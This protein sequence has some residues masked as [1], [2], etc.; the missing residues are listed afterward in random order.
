M[1]GMTLGRSFL[2][3]FRSG[4]ALYNIHREESFELRRLH[5]VLFVA[6]IPRPKSLIR[7]QQ[8]VFY[9]SITRLSVKR[10]GRQLVGISFVV[11]EKA[12]TK[13]DS[14]MT[15]FTLTN[16]NGSIVLARTVRYDYHLLLIL[17]YGTKFFKM[18]LTK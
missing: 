13:L 7:Y 5:T 4:Y 12:K 17:G 8:Y 3:C 11:K 6:N 14:K 16:A 1:Y 2:L 18:F 10:H 9:V 15:H